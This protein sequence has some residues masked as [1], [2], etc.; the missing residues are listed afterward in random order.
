MPRTPS[1]QVVLTE[2]LCRPQRIGLFGRRGVGKTTFLTML[3]R[4]AVGGRL[5][6]LRLAAADARTADYLSDKVLQLEA[7]QPL[8]ATLGETELRFHLYHGETRLELLIKDYQGEHVAVGRQ[9]PIR[10][11]LRDCDAVWLCLDVLDTATPE[12]LLCAEQEVEQLVEDYLTAEP[13]GALHRPMA[14]VLT[15]A[16]LLG[17]DA[18]PPDE[19][20]REQFEMTRHALATHFPRHEM[21]AVSSLGGTLE[22]KPAV[23]TPQPVGLEGPL[24]WLAK[25][26]RQQDLARL[27][28]L[29]PSAARQTAV[30]ERASG[31]FARRYP[32]EPE[33][34]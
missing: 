33:T 27:E 5:P 6:R 29:W 13:E 4:E 28:Q 22:G 31:C 16:D 1:P 30:I 32:A 25:V 26:L 7:G 23:F 20:V 19:L 21:F 12:S 2:R 3:Y 11:F 17:H 18:P 9:E 34:T 15:K 10:E 24:V 14:V 8:P